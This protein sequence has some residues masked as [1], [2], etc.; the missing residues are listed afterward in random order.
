MSPD[1]N[2]DRVNILMVDDQPAKLL[3]YEAILK[4]LGE[5]LL[6][7]SSGREALEALL[8]S[9]IAVIL[10]D[11]CMPELDG[12]ELASMIRDHPRFQKTA[13]IFVSAIQVTDLDRLRGYEMGAVD[14]LP[15]PL[16][17]EVLRAKIR[18][19]TELYRKTRQL[20]QLNAELEARVSARTAELEASN[21][22]LLQSEQRRNLALVAGKM[23]S[24]DWDLT[25]DD[26]LWDDGQ[27]RIFGVDPGTFNVR[28][29]TVRPM[30]HADDLQATHKAVESVRHGASSFETEFRIVRPDG[31]LRWCLCTAAST[32]DS[33]GRVVRVSGVTIDITERKKA[34]ERQAL[35]A[36]E[37]DHRAKNALALVQSIVRLTKADN[38]P[39]YVRAV[40]GRITAL[41]RVHTVLAHARWQGADIRGIIDEEL[42]PY[43]VGDVD[44]VSMDGPSIFLQPTTSQTLALSVHELA[45]N[46]A[47]YGAL[48][49]EH[50]KVRVRWNVEDDDLH[51]MWEEIGGPTVREPTARGFGTRSVIASIETQLQGEAIFDWR[52]EGLICRMRVPGKTNLMAPQ[53]GA[54]LIGHRSEPA[55]LAIT[56]SRILLVEDEVVVAMTMHEMLTELGYSVRGPHGRLSDAFADA[57]EQPPDAAILDVNLNGEMIYPLAEFLMKQKVPF[58]FVTGYGAESIDQR[59]VGIPIL[60]KPID[61]HALERIFPSN[62]LAS[63][64]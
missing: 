25:A 6:I 57:L 53:R 22:R 56:G 26:H 32:M 12:F 30:I 41:A 44:R 38:V 51:L 52:P 7:A 23:G 50:G 42:A 36:R 21:F 47:K 43:Q 33:D 49:V 54:P 64:R 18:V 29:E 9:E 20:E 59:F 34:E 55:P 48:S 4:D 39:H 14:Y 37:V 62:A 8:K 16:V 46:A 24:W 19:F 58:L 35:L 13:I 61:R 40:E 45:T 63:A 17:P 5:N 3:A 60:Q 11:V 15:V 2:R 1:I 10:V 27:F 31:D 28:P